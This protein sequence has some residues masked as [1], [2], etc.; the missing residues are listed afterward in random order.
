[1][2]KLSTIHGGVYLVLNPAMETELLLARLASALAGGLQAVQIW[3]NWPPGSVRLDIIEAIG[4]LC[5][6]HNVPLLINQ[7]W[8]LLLQSPWLQGVHFD[9]IPADF[10]HIKK[11]INRSFLTGITCSSNLDTVVWAD[12]N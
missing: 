4:Q 12:R 9:N 1:M 2:K 5:G 6:Q 3:N 7:E 11:I 8:E 10:E